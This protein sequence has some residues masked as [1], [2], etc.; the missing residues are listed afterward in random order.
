MSRNLCIHIVER[1]FMKFVQI[2]NNL[3]II[4]DRLNAIRIKAISEHS[5]WILK[6]ESNAFEVVQ[7]N[8]HCG[9]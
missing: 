3:N 9:C 2:M 7:M 6:A 8:L 1:E 5:S 4:I